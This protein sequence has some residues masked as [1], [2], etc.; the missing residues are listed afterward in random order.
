M[1]ARFLDWL[2]RFMVACEPLSARLRDDPRLPSLRSDAEALGRDWDAVAGDLW[3][4]AHS[5]RR[6]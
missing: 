6:R 1:I 4:A 5:L 2:G 3:H